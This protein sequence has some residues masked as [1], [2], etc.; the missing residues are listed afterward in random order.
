VRGRAP[1]SKVP[2]GKITEAPPRDR[3]HHGPAGE[4]PQGVGRAREG[5]WTGGEGAAP[6][7]PAPASGVYLR[8]TP[9]GRRCAGGERRGTD[10]AGRDR[11]LDCNRKGALFQ[12]GNGVRNLAGV[13]LLIV[14]IVVGL[15]LPD[16]DLRASFLVHRSIVTHGLLLPALSYWV[17]R[18]WER[19]AS[20]LFAI[21]VALSTAVHLC[22]DLFPRAWTGYALIH[23][24]VYGRASPVLSWLWIAVSI[25]V[26]MYLALVLVRSL[27]DVVAVAGGGIATFITCAAHESVL[28]PALTA[29]VMATA[30]AL[31]FPASRGRML[32]GQRDTTSL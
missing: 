16:L 32:K 21:G 28:W 3:F 19:A 25:V 22:F 24:P 14:G 11:R 29:L 26:C 13:L 23:I 27:F 1:G 10:G 5:H 4:Q 30:V 20:H 6:G 9:R 2:R 31:V 15:V 17:A 18:R 12:G 8:Q 7:R